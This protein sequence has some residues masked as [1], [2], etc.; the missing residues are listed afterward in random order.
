[1]ITN[2]LRLGKTTAPAW[3]LAAAKARLRECG[4]NVVRA[5]LVAPGHPELVRLALRETLGGL[6]ALCFCLLWFVRWL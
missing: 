3:P 2:R 6:S 1:M 4:L 5:C